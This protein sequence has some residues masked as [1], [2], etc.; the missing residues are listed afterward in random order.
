MSESDASGLGEVLVAGGAG[1]LGSALVDSLRA[2][3]YSVAVLSRAPGNVAPRPGVRAIGWHDEARW[4]DCATGAAA[5]VNLCGASVAGT[6]WTPAY[7]DELRTSRIEPTLRLASA[8]P[9]ALIQGSA[10]GVYGDRGDEELGEDSAPGNDFLARLGVEWEAAAEGARS[11]G[12]R[13][14]LLRTGQ[15]LGRDGGMLPAL[16][17]P[18]MLPFSPWLLGLGGPLGDGRAWMPWIHVADWVAMTERAIEDADWSGPVNA[19]SPHPVR[20]RDFARALGAALHRPALLPVPRFALRALAGEFADALL[21]SQRVLPRAAVGHGF[22]FR[23]PDVAKALG[24]LLA[25]R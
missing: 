7:R 1:F 16:L 14:V 3:G 4:R 12:G 9:R 17:R 5:V 24:D 18:P 25:V 15:V 23:F 21:A 6:R 22:A 11:A 2:R 20:N 8:G 19:V 13:L 10:V